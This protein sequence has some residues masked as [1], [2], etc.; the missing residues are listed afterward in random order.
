MEIEKV[1]TIKISE[2]EMAFRM[3]DILCKRGEINQATYSNI[4]QNKNRYIS[5]I[6]KKK[7]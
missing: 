1:D 5:Q 3:I 4:L 7:V 2:Q 6:E